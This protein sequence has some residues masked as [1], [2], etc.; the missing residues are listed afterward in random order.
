MQNLEISKLSLKIDLNNLPENIEYKDGE[1]SPRVGFE[2][3]IFPIKVTINNS[4]RKHDNTVHT[5]SFYQK[6]VKNESH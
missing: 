6:R 2:F 5:P 1:K 3:V 4:K